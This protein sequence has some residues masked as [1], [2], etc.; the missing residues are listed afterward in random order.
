MTLLLPSSLGDETFVTFLL[1]VCCVFIRS[2][3]GE[4]FEGHLEIVLRPVSGKETHN[5]VALG[6]PSPVLKRFI[7]GLTGTDH[8]RRAF[9]RL[10]GWLLAG[11]TSFAL[12]LMFRLLPFSR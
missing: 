4:D 11:M 7:S 10:K 12:R 2:Q 1:C 6:A 8:A 5:G 3:I 9:P